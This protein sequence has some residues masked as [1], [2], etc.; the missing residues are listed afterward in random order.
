M[1]KVSLIVGIT[2]LAAVL[3]GCRDNPSTLPPGV[4]SEDFRYADVAVGD[5]TGD[6]QNDIVL[7]VGDEIQLLVN[8][9]NGR[10]ATPVFIG[11]VSPRAGFGLRDPTVALGDVTGDGLVDIVLG[12]RKGVTV[13]KNI[14]GNKFEILQ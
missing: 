1:K 2:A 11:K 4:A 3:G 7:V 8:T 10:F 6:G 9:G 13:L 5:V 14:G 12:D